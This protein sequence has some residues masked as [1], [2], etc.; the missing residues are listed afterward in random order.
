MLAVGLIHMNARL[1][2]PLLHRFLSPDNYV[3]DPFNS[4]N[5]NRYAYV[6]NNPLS[7]V[8]PSGEF[9][10][11]LAIAIG[12][13]IGAASGGAAYIG[14]ALRTGNWSWGQF[15][16]SV[17]GGAVIGGITGGINPMSIFSAGSLGGIAATGF[18]AGLLPSV[19]GH[20][21]D[22]SFSI[23]P[24][25][26]FGQSFGVGANLSVGYSSGK[27]AIS[28]GLGYMAYGNYQGF[29]KSGSEIRESVMAAYDT[30]KN[31]F[32]LGTNNWSGTG[33]METFGQRTGTLGLHFGNF[34][35]LYEN[36]GSIGPGGDGGDSYRSAALNLSVG[37]FTVGF[38]LFTGYRDYE[39][40]NGSVS[41]HR[42]P[43]CIDEYSR[44]MPNGVVRELN[45]PYRLGALTVGYKNYRIGTNSEHV[46][47]AIQ[48]QSI[49]NLKFLFLDKRQMG[50]SNQSWNWGGY[51]QYHTRNSFTSW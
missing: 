21:G 7:H 25:I 3:Q 51:F 5:Y 20:I 11:L 50:F 26:A 4:Q 8:D 23:S 6:L 17:L 40:E 45:T 24:A 22:F 44:R 46:R 36:D 39:N 42:D 15:G 43:L 35:A 14:S 31:G 16:L 27:F 10:P 49:H 13:L 28:A 37:D 47:H 1:Y 34:R 41:Q 32:S 48:D 38:N 18:A 29:G 33:G 2:D 30:G 19:N 12:A 9:I